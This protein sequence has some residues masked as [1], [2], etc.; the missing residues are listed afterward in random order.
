MNRGMWSDMVFAETMFSTG[1]LSREGKWVHHKTIVEAVPG[2]LF[3]NIK[4]RSNL[5]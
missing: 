3:K 1:H 2:P 5:Y 4:S